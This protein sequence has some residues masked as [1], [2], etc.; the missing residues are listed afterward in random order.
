MRTLLKVNAETEKINSR[1][2]LQAGESVLTRQMV[3]VK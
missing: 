2:H 3:L 1:T